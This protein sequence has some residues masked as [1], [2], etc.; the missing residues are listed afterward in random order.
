LAQGLED[1]AARD[2]SHTITIKR[3]R[4]PNATAVTVIGGKRAAHRFS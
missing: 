4:R 2:K 1:K 3:N